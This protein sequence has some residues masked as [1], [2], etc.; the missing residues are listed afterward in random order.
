METVTVLR[1]AQLQLPDRTC[2][3]DLLII[4]NRIGGVGS[5]D[6]PAGSAG[7]DL[8]GKT[9]APGLVDL[10][11]N[12]FA[13]VEVYEATPEALQAIVEELPRTGCTSVLLTMIS[14]PRARYDALFDAL[15]TLENEPASG[16]RVLGL[17]LEG[18]YLNRAHAGA[19]PPAELRPPDLGE[20]RDL[21]DRADGR[22]KMWTIAPE[23]PGSD[24]LIELLLERGVVVAAG[25]SALTYAQARTCF[26][27]GVSFVTHLFNAMTPFHHREIGLPGAALFDS[28]VH[29][30]LVADGHHVS[31]SAVKL[32]TALA[33]SRLILVTDAVAAA[34]MSN[35]DFLVGGIP[36]R[37]DA[38]VVRRPDGRLAGSSITALESV[39]NLADWG[40]L[41]MADVLVAMSARPADILDRPD[42]GRLEAGALADLL[43]LD[44]EDEL[45]ETW[46]DGRRVFAGETAWSGHAESLASRTSFVSEESDR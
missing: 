38:G 19:H 40:E 6:V 13:G 32:V 1:N 20:A 16:A 21:L 35:G 3:G 4:G 2:R 22:I 7:V 44:G 42:L 27:R 9:V 37:L 41:S 39:R 18:P 43:V 36:G 5:F 24:A 45:C 10:Q 11:L 23:L 33:A 17:H 29:F 30:G 31:P 12:G 34:G 15:E 26:G 14:A 8:A 25:H 46:I 28:R